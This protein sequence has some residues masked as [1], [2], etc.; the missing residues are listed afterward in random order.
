MEL[1]TKHSHFSTYREKTIEHLFIGEVLR[2]FWRNG[3][4]N[5][6]V[7]RCEFDRGGYD[8]VIS[9]GSVSRFIQFKTALID[10][11]VKDVKVSLNLV[12]KPNACV[13][14]IMVDD[15]LNLAGFKWFGA[16]VGLPFPDIKSMGIA[17]HTKANSKG[18][19]SERIDHRLLK[20]SVFESCADIEDIIG[21]FF[22]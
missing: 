8:L 10:S 21:K 22:E 12:A 7:L 13:V 14:L 20:L 19:K 3:E 1:R 11:S 17:K 6:E 18:I 5:V 16:G 15:A 2:Y 9:R 4:T